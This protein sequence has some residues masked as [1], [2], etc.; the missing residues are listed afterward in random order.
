MLFLN[1][2]NSLS[3]DVLS[4]LIPMKEWGFLICFHFRC[5]ASG[6]ENKHF[7]LMRSL[8]LQTPSKKAKPIYGKAWMFSLRAKA[9]DPLGVILIQLIIKKGTAKILSKASM[10]LLLRKKLAC[11]SMRWSASHANSFSL[12]PELLCATLPLYKDNLLSM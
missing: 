4:E 9:N 5:G 3:D 10:C 7:L 11:V 1:L 8:P 6:Q 2:H 12:F